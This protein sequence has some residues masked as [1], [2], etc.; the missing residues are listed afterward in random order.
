MNTTTTHWTD[1]TNISREDY[2]SFWQDRKARLIYANEEIISAA[3]MNLL[4]DMSHVHARNVVKTNQL[5]I[6]ECDDRLHFSA[7]MQK[8][9]AAMIAQRRAEV[10]AANHPNACQKC[11]GL[12]TVRGFEH[13]CEGVC[14]RCGG[15]GVIG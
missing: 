14:F 15:S 6:D 11:S 12:G 1:Q 13:I 10:A 8:D 4:D 2:K 5:L 9:T 3:A 7:V